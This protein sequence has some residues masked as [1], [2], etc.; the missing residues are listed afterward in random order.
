MTTI[1]TRAGKGSALTHN[2][3]DSNFTN[4]NN[5]KYESGNNAT[6]GTIQG[7]TITATTAF[8]GALNGTVGA[9]TPAAGT[10]TTL[11]A[12]STVSGTGFSTYLASPPAIGGTSPAAITGTSGTFTSLS[13]SGNLTFTGTGNRI[14]GEFSTATFAN[15]VYFQTSTTNSAT[16]VGAIPNGTGTNGTYRVFNSSDP[17]NSSTGALVCSATSVDINSFSY[18]TGT[19]LPMTFSTGGSE[20]M[21]IDTI[22]NVG[23]GTTSPSARLTVDGAV[24]IFGTTT[25][26][27]RL[28]INPSTLVTDVYAAGTDTTINT[29]SNGS[30]NF[31]TNNTERMRIDS[32]GNLLVG[33]TSALVSGTHS[34]VSG[35]ASPLTLRNSG[36]TAGRFWYTGPDA[37]ANY[38]VYNNSSVGMFMAYGGTSW[39]SSS[40]ERLKTN[41]TPIENGLDKVNTLRSVTG[42]FKTDDESVSR[43]F[44][45]AQDIQKVL[46]E[47]V[48]VQ[49]DEQGTLGVAYTDVIPLL[50]AAI[51]ELNA[52]VTALEAQLQGN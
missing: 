26:G 50:V 35:G 49:D 9:T 1:V 2:E 21:R 46:P 20:R 25:S 12:S 42:R 7:S 3:V 33:T 27:Y 51:K 16:V 5:A 28:Y 13:D 4:L 38:L 6:L 30:L 18:G 32:S 48:H 23:I 52:K 34:F 43:A 40:D 24:R 36:S 17:A 14:L 31:G 19:F 8:S 29:V 22:G 37:S 11:S 44:L 47:A 10:F 45:I 39:S 15:R 41:L